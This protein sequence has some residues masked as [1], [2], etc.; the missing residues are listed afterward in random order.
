[1]G[2]NMIVHFNNVVVENVCGHKHNHTYLFDV[3]KHLKHK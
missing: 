2:D 3:E 1:M